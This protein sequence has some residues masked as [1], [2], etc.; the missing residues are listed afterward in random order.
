MPAR[1]GSP[2]F[3]L[4]AHVAVGEERDLAAHERIH[5]EPRARAARPCESTGKSLEH[6]DARERVEAAVAQPLEI[7]RV[8]AAVQHA[9]ERRAQVVDLLAVGERRDE[10]RRPRLPFHLNSRALEAP[11]GEHVALVERDAGGGRGLE[12]RASTRAAATPATRRA[13]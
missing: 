1:I 10:Q 7:G 2:V 6:V 3:S 11:A 12:A 8:G 9:R 5:R 4:V 13:A